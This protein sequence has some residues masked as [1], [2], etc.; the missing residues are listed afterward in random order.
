MAPV[1]PGRRVHRTAV[2]H[3]QRGRLTPGP[4]GPGAIEVGF[5]S[6]ARTGSRSARL[7]RPIAGIRN[8]LDLAGE[9]WLLCKSGK[10]E[11]EV[12]MATAT[13]LS[14]LDDS[15]LGLEEPTAHMHVGWTALFDPPM[16]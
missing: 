14:P 11:E 12:C 16:Q 10:S 15:F 7:T 9:C 4:R 1:F 6:K 3:D 8:D 13:R 5:L 2:L